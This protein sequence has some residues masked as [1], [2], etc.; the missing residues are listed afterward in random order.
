[1][2]ISCVDFG[3]TQPDKWRSG[4]L[5]WRQRGAGWK[6]RERAPPQSDRRRAVARSRLL[7]ALQMVQ[8]RRYCASRPSCQSIRRPRSQ[9]SRAKVARQGSAEICRPIVLRQRIQRFKWPC[10]AVVSCPIRKASVSGRRFA[11]GR[12]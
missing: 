11:R 3:R 8:W 2:M 5:P 7:G 12:P 4:P 1:M 10:R 6:S 9:R